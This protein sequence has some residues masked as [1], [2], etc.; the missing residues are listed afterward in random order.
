MPVAADPVFLEKL[1]RRI[2]HTKIEE[3]HAPRPGKKCLVLD[4]DYTI[5]DLGTP[6][7]TASEKARPF[8]HEFLTAVNAGPVLAMLCFASRQ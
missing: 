4:I 5:F 1:A 8:L 7:E 6:G 3:L 2:A